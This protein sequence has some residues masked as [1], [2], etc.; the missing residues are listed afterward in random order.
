MEKIKVAKWNNKI[1]Q[2][3]RVVE[4]VAFSEEKEWILLSNQVNKKDSI[5]LRWVR[6]KDVRFDWVREFTI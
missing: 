4:S 6:V 3:I 1:Y 2:I 5:Q